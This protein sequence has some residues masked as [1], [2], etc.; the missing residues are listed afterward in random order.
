RAEREML[1]QEVHDSDALFTIP[2]NTPGEERAMLQQPVQPTGWTDEPLVPR[3][4]LAESG[5]RQAGIRFRDQAK[6]QNMKLFMEREEK[7]Q[8]EGKPFG[9]VVDQLAGSI[10]GQQ[11]PPQLPPQLPPQ[12]ATAMQQVTPPPNVDPAA[13]VDMETQ[14][15]ETE[16]ITG[17]VSMGD[18]SGVQDQVDKDMEI[19]QA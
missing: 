19:E 1:E 11:P 5:V 10:A 14:P 17:D 4:R 3:I 15:A 6:V 9:S 16:K 8:R 7:R 18:E 2:G 13:I 12:N